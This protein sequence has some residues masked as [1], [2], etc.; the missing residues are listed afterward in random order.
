MPI[1]NEAFR[2]TF[3]DDKE[4]ALKKQSKEL[5]MRYIPVVFDKDIYWRFG[6]MGSIREQC[7]RI[8]RYDIGNTLED[9][10]KFKTA[11]NIKQYISF[12]GIV[13]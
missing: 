11:T 1:V 10:T 3:A 6:A 2:I 13:S 12:R 4:E 7:S 8:R 5:E 9:L